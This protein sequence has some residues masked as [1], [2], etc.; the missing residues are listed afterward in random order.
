M[1]SIDSVVSV[2]ISAQTSFPTRQGFGK[3]MLMAYHTAYTDLFREY[4]S[5]AGLVADGLTSDSAAYKMAL[6]AFSQNPRPRTVKIGRITT[7]V[8]PTYDVTVTTATAAKHVMLTITDSDG[9]ST[10]IDYT[11]TGSESSGTTG[12]ATAV[13]LLIEAVTGIASTSSG[14]VI[15]VVGTSGKMFWIKGLLN[16]T[17]SDVTADANIDD[18]LTA[19][20]LI[21]DD[22]YGVA[23][24]Y[25]SKANT[26]N[27]AAWTETQNKIFI[28]QTPNA[29]ELT[30]G[31]T[32]G[33]ALA[34]QSYDN[35]GIIFNADTEDYISAGLL[36]KL[37]PQ[38]PG[39]YTAKFK[40][41]AGSTADTLNDT[42]IGYLDG[43]NMNHYDSV[44]GI[45]MIREGVMSSGQFID[46]TVFI[47]WLSAR[48]KERIFTAIS[49]LPKL[50]YTN[51]GLAVLGAE[52]RA[53]LAIGVAVGGLAAGT[54][55]VFV[56]KV[57]DIDPAERA[58]RNVVGLTFSGRLAGAAHSAEIVG[59]VTV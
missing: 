10:D 28:C 41:V 44:A 32:Q 50:P 1:S 30:S 40:T 45:S 6:S 14:A 56:P 9:N 33:H 4:S 54:V 57:E 24:Q 55:S 27:V 46:V 8:A 13:E 58:A 48:M 7:S 18:D 53:V 52:M 5:L 17:I 43:D 25:A 12:V 36:G 51:D 11:V 34:G 38:D 29:L 49:N 16:C 15:N 19:I 2:Q 37:L 22:W 47:H 39:S 3:S 26:D 21:D 31:G 35:T 42:E 23:I 59:T 20:Q